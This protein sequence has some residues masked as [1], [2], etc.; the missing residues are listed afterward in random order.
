MIDS[1]CTFISSFPLYLLNQLTFD[2][3]P[4]HIVIADLI[5][6]LSI[7]CMQESGEQPESLSSKDA[8]MF[9]IIASATLFGLYLFFQVQ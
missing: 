9:P 4:Y 3:E 1:I 8:A 6:F 5:Y 7:C 2:T